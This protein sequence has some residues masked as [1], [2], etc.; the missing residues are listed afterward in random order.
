MTSFGGIGGNFILDFDG[1]VGVQE[2]VAGVSHDGGAARR[3]A[4]L[5]QEAQEAGEELVHLSGGVELG[6]IA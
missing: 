6:E 4:I 5:G 1:A 2:E 3:D